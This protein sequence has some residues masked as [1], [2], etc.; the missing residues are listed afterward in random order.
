MLEYNGRIESAIFESNE[1]DLFKISEKYSNNNLSNDE[2][3]LLSGMNE[4]TMGQFFTSN[5]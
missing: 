5:Q 2:I 1:N 4:A 3:G